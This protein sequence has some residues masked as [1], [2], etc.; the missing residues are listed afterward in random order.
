[1]DTLVER[2]R[3]EA[4][5][6]KEGEGDPFPQEVKDLCRGL[7]ALFIE[8]ADYIERLEAASQSH[9]PIPVRGEPMACPCGKCGGG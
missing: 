1:M 4:S 7:S 6:A 3:A 8:A 9:P 2:L 5:E